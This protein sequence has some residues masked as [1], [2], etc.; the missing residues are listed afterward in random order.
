L[1]SIA[2]EGFRRDSRRIDLA[3]VRVVLLEGGPR[4]LPTFSERLALRA[5]RDLEELGSSVPD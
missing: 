1:P 5:C 3:Q 2:R 4:F